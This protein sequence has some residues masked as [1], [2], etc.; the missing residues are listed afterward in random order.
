[1][2]L[3]A[4]YFRVRRA[5]F[6]T[7]IALSVLQTAYLLTVPGFS[8]AV[9]APIVIGSAVALYGLLAAAM[10]VRGKTASIVVL[11]LLILRYVV[12]YLS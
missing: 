3:D 5:V 9:R 1:V 6:G 8:E 12:Q 2:D 10:L 7:L 11:V 4:H